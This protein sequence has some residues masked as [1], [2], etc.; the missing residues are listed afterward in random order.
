MAALSPLPHPELLAPGVHVAG[1]SDRYRSANCGWAE[2]K[3]E[4]LLI[5]LPRGMD[6]R[7]FL[8]FVA[9]STGKLVRS[10]VLPHAL[11]GDGAILR[12]LVR[13]GVT[14]VMASPATRSKLLATGGAGPSAVAALDDRAAIGDATVAVDFL[15]FD[16]VGGHGGV[17]YLPG[18]SV[19]FAGPLVVH[20]PRA[21]LTRSNTALWVSTLLELEAL[22]PAR[23]VPGFGSVG[24]TE[25]I[26]RK[27]RFLTELRRQIGHHIA[28]GRFMAAMPDQLRLPGASLVLRPYDHPNRDDLEHVYRELTVPFAPFYGRV[29]SSLDPR[30][31]APVLIG[32]Q[33]HEPGHLEEG[34][35][36]A[37]A[38]TGVA[39]HFTVDVRALS[40]ENVGR[41]QLLVM[42]RDGLLRQDE[43]DHK[44]V[45]WMTPEQERAIAPFVAKGGGFL[46]L[47][48]SMGL[49]PP[50]GPYL[51]LVGGRF[52][53]QGPL[54]RFRVE[55]VDPDDAV[56][57]GVSPFFIADEQHT[58]LYAEG[59][60]HVLLKSRS[61]DGKVAPAGWV[62]E[63][64][65]GR[66]CHLA[67]GHTR[68][69]LLHPMYQ[70][71]V[72]NAVRW[73]LRRDA[74]RPRSPGS[75]VVSYQ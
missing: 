6:V 69:A 15:P 34:L 71:L 53:S 64:G 18:R 22:A 60:V 55:V 41:V 30:P 63:V 75:P 49:Y 5:D 29:P 14:C 11:D 37:F 61:D 44:D 68:E 67:N 59:R 47:H 35:R 13:Q 2:L 45:L 3:Q 1:F 42:L 57:R 32:D 12:A 70:K 43:N 46:N 66:R 62:R 16:D 20:G 39:C 23:V 38:A 7:K 31:Q 10:L 17:V 9:S 40:A 52:G 56:T 24:G 26:T 4:T 65:R 8:A 36:P 19:L 51:D 48:N 28:Q 74:T 25:L 27:S 54:E 58:P 50:D 73:C 33:P 21:D 72:R